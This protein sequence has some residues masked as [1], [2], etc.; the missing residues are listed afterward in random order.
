MLSWHPWSKQQK[1]R[2]NKEGF[3]PIGSPP[4]TSW[5]CLSGKESPCENARYY[6]LISAF[7]FDAC[8]KLSD[9]CDTSYTRAPDL[10]FALNILY[11]EVGP[12]VGSRVEAMLAACNV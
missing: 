6:L 3:E 12:I 1:Q 11:E 7:C 8:G 5:Q 10:R 2:F 9:T 4:E